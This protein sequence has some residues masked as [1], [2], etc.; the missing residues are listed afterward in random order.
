MLNKRLIKSGIL[1][2]QGKGEYQYSFFSL[3]IVK[4]YKYIDIE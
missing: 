4:K 3:L 1:L 2:M